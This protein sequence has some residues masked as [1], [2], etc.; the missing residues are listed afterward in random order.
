MVGQPAIVAQRV[1][2]LDRGGMMRVFDWPSLTLKS[3]LDLG[4]P[5]T[6]L[7]ATERSLHVGLR[8]GG[9]ITIPIEAGLPGAPRRVALGKAAVSQ[10]VWEPNGARLIALDQRGELFWLRTGGVVQR[11]GAIS[12]PSPVPPLLWND[13]VHVLAESGGIESMPL[14]SGS[15]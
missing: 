7:V 3:E 6:G 11:I 2:T 5:T 10:L 9:V 12:G 14:L 13:T 8:D 1:W 15:P 4:P